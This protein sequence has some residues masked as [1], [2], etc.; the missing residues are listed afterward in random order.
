[1]IILKHTEYACETIYAHLHQAVVN[2]NQAVKRG[3]LIGYMGNSG[4]ST[5]PHLHYEVRTQNRCVNP[6]SFILP[7]DAV[8]D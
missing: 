2:K 1:V 3:E 5:G 7:T 4:R 6:L 8:V